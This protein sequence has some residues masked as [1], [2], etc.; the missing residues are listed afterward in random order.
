MEAYGTIQE[1]QARGID[2][3][4]L[5]GMKKMGVGSDGSDENME[6]PRCEWV[7]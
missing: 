2:T 4:R 5:L 6:I 1:M 3:N 7:I